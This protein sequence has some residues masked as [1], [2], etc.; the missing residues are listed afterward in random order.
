MMTKV[1]LLFVNEFVSRLKELLEIIISLKILQSMFFH[2]IA[3]LKKCVNHPHPFAKGYITSVIQCYFC[4]VYPVHQTLT[5][6]TPP[7]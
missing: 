5:G 6:D 2:K 7:P 1:F 3:N 4:N